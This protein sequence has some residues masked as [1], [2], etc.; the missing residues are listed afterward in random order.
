M[1]TEQQLNDLGAVLKA[2]KQMKAE[3]EQIIKETSEQIIK[4][5]AAQEATTLETGS[6]RMSVVVTERVRYDE[7]SLKACIKPKV[8][9]QITERKL[10]PSLVE[11][12]VKAGVI[13]VAAVRENAQITTSA[14]YVRMTEK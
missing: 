1:S 11:E 4:E 14:P 9:R 3:A 7:A 2:A 6:Y 8:W 10:V 5:A 12:A 13:D